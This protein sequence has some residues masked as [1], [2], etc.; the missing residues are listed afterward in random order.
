DNVLAVAGASHGNLW[1]LIFGLG[2]SIPL[3]VGASGILSQL[4]DRYP[5]IAYLGSAVLGRVG[6]EM[7]LHEK[8]IEHALALS[9]YAEWGIEA[10]TALGVVLLARTLMARRRSPAH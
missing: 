4:M 3:V 7:I 5:I 9:K 2:L 10:A 8:S 1:L 6:A